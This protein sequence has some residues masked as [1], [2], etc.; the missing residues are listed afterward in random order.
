MNIIIW[1]ITQ[2]LNLVD[3]GF[4]AFGEWSECSADCGEGEQTR[5]R[6]CNNPAPSNGGAD[7][8]GSLKEAKSCSGSCP[9]SLS[10]LLYLNNV[11]VIR[12]I[13]S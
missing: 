10:S 2:F 8:K 13:S 5:E 1:Y 11:I 3:G 9:G 7:C 4:S 12:W 6:S